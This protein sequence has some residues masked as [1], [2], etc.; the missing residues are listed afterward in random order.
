MTS[1][2]ESAYVLDCSV[3][4]SWF[5]IDENNPKSLQLQQQIISFNAVIPT[6]WF[7][8]VANV[9]SMSLQRKRIDEATLEESIQVIQNL[10]IVID[11]KSTK[12]TLSVTLYLAQKHQL[13][14][15]DAA[16]LELA[17]REGLPLATFDK[18]LANI[19]KVCGIPLA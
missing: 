14:L 10:P 5:L 12:N 2:R 11:E 3:A 15:Y 17:M 9:L 16:Y 18:M 19:A 7:Y 4:M 1:Q 13:S 8:E 6:I